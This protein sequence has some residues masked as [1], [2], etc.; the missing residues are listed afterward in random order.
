MAKM[1]EQVITIND[2]DK[3]RLHLWGSKGS[4]QIVPE[5]YSRSF[6]ERAG[7]YISLAT[8]GEYDRPGPSVWFYL[9]LLFLFFVGGFFLGMGL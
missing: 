9:F 8:P 7:I 4:L 1:A 6:H 3:E 5:A 2:D